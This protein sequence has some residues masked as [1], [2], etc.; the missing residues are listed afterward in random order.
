MFYEQITI[1]KVF[2]QIELTNHRAGDTQNAC[3]NALL[4]MCEQF[5][6]FSGRTATDLRRESPGFSITRRSAV[7]TVE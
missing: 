1:F 7:L 6:S 4:L 3:W 5:H 2:S